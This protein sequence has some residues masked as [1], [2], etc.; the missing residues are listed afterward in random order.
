[1]PNPVALQGLA[2]GLQALAGKL[3]E[4]QAQQALPVVP[5]SLA[6][7][8]KEDEAADWARS[9]VALSRR[10]AERDKALV[11]A[12]SSDAHPAQAPRRPELGAAYSRL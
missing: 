1:M 5:S 7:A 6:W 8:G 4:A 11:A 9:Q 12:K 10:P 3:T 2:L